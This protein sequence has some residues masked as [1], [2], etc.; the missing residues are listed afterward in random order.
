M[1]ILT[2]KGDCVWMNIYLDGIY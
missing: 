1:T 2:R